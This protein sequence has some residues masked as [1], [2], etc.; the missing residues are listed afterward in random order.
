MKPARFSYAAPTSMSEALALLAESDDARV[1]A[2]GQSL[3][4]MMNMRLAQP[5]LLVDINRI[6]GLSG[7]GL[8]AGSLV[9]GAM[10]RHAGLA[11][12]ALVKAHAPVLAYAAGTIGHYA[13]RQRGTIGG[14]LAHA[15][16]AAQL[17]LVCMLLDARIDATS[18]EGAR[19]IE[20]ADLFET[21]FTTT[22]E[23]SEMITSISV[24]LR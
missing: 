22:L 14:S 23:P 19:T 2:G 1:I 4:P 15:D 8:D 6:D 5:E 11:G 3:A 17:P 24:P 20:A 10:T 16:P 7:V 12:N 18:S 9:I 21:L 13:I